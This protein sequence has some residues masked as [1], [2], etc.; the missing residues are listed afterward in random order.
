MPRSRKPGWHPVRPGRRPSFVGPRKGSPERARRTLRLRGS[1]SPLFGHRK[2]EK[3]LIAR[4]KIGTTWYSPSMGSAPD[5][6]EPRDAE[7]AHGPERTEVRGMTRVSTND[8]SAVHPA[9]QRLLAVMMSAYLVVGGLLALSLFT[10]NG[11][12]ANFSLTL[13]GTAAAG[14][15]LTPGTETNPGP[16]LRANEGDVVSVHMISEDALSHGLFIDFNDNNVI[17]PPQDYSSPVGTD[18]AFTFTVPP[19]PGQH[20]YYCS[21]HSASGDPYVGTFYFPGALMYGSFVVNGKPS[22]SFSVPTGAGSWTSGTAHTIEFNLLDESPPTSL[23]LWVN[24][25]YNGGSV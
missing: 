19:L 6:Q 5:A 17:D 18:E 14:W 3:S 10:T 4:G 12:G 8:R 1:S 9:R 21:M 2:W 25:S 15:S 7:D 23:T 13:Y 11:S 20:T 16:T 24:Y 22:A